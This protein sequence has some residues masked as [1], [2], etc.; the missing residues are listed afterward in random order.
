MDIAFCFCNPNSSDLKEQA[1][2]RKMISKCT[3]LLALVSIT[4]AQ[5][6]GYGA[7]SSYDK[8]SDSSSSSSAASS[9]SSHESSSSQGAV[10]GGYGGVVKPIN[11]INTAKQAFGNLNFGKAHGAV[12]RAQ[13]H[14]AVNRGQSLGTSNSGYGNNNAVRSNLGNNNAYSASGA[15]ARA[16]P[17][18]IK[19]AQPAR[20][21]TGYGQRQVVRPSYSAQAP[22]YGQEENN[23][24]MP[25]HFAYN[26][27]DDYDTTIYREETADEYGSVTGSYG[28]QDAYGIYRQVEYT[29]DD[30]GFRAQ[31][32]TNEPGTASK[33]P[34]DVEIYADPIETAYAAPQQGYQ[35]T[36]P[37]VAN[38]RS[39]PQSAAPQQGYQNTAPKVANARSYPQRVAAPH[40][41]KQLMEC[42]E[43]T[44]VL[45]LAAIAL[46]Q[47]KD[48]THRRV[49]SVHKTPTYGHQNQGYGHQRQ[50]YGQVRPAYSAHAP[51]Y[52]QESYEEPRPYEF[53]FNIKD[54]YNTEI[55]RQET[56]D[57]YG[58]VK[59]SYGYTD[60][61]GL[62]RQVEYTADEYGFKANIKTNE[63]GTDNQN[64]ADVLIY[65]EPAQV[66]YDAPKKGY[67]N[68]H[69]TVAHAP[70]YGHRSYA[71][72]S[73]GHRDTYAAPTY[74]QR[75]SY[76]PA[77]KTSHVSTH[78]R[79][80]DDK[81]GAVALA[82]YKDNSHKRVHA[83]HKTPSYGHQNQGYGHQRQ[84][85]GQVRPA[86][87]AHAP[88]Y[89]QES[90]E[91]PRPYEFAFNS[92]DD[93]NTE[94]HRQETGDDYGN[95][96]GSYG[97]T[98]AYGLYRQVEYTADEYGFKANIKTNEPGTDNQNPADVLIYAEPAEVKYDAPKKGYNNAHKAVAHAPSYGQRSYA[99]PS[100]GHRDTYAAPTYGH[101]AS[102]APAHKTSH[103]STHRRGYDDKKGGRLYNLLRGAQSC[104][105]VV[106]VGT[107]DGDYDM[108][109][110]SIELIQHQ[111]TPGELRN[112][113]KVFE[114]VALAQ[115][116]DNTHRGVHSVHK[117]PTYGHQNQGYGHQRQG[118]GQ[119]RP[120]YSAHAPSYKQE[121]YEE[122]RP[123]EFAFNS[124][125]DYNTE[126]HRQETG[127]DY[128]NVKGSY[129]YTD[130]Y[131]LYRQVE[132][133]AD[134]YGFKA[135]I[136]TNEPGTDNQNPADV[137]I[138]AEPAEVKY[139]A[140][141]KGYNNAHKAVAHAPSYGQRSYAAPSYGHRDTYAA[142]TYG[143]RAS[144]APAHKTSHVSTHRRGYD[145]KKG[146]YG[147]DS[148][149]VSHKAIHH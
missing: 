89:K 122:P 141:K 91:E 135:N 121:S 59:G 146:G 8:K 88:S 130:A 22:S 131:G 129:G 7:V 73:Y 15:H 3:L 14:G 83:V 114:A 98:D 120:A 95:V 67:N 101:R 26:V 81:K 123:Y 103:V 80:Y 60:A 61:Y 45:A 25:Y 44:I 76:A 5:Y 40:K 28:Y 90:Y 133:T 33:N 30:N 39:Y 139:D 72:P 19:V 12:N 62:Y 104:S 29:A 115:Y 118:Y 38:A 66:K 107:D 64:P 111:L 96:K 1:T 35:N 132:Y 34:A 10:L 113:N 148:H 70:S 47:Y 49:H 56:G 77:H 55:H 86:Y 116:K 112:L 85:Y 100:Y 20:S 2:E 54:D 108:R 74:G 53:A 41:V 119:V 24:P 13:V 144:F 102:Y 127:D 31:I 4:V 124:K 57:D 110:Y 63:P 126:I 50:G 92:K 140:P 149:V 84:G 94:I 87:S 99:A 147:H 6:T 136:K 106:L 143:H 23:G 71:A 32:K 137:L 21:N 27:K 65:A 51:S 78:R 105:E 97:Y 37:K 125:D 75:A 117:T 9:S 79:G 138:Y 36:A 142:P 69:K 134:E 58:N 46:A 109:S 145:D 48:N 11:T 68:A 93:Y 52:K 42:I 18:R 82:Q 43:I 128:G 17:R 16:G